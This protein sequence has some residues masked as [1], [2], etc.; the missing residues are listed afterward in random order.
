MT[1]LALYAATAAL[2]A[3]APIDS[4]PPDPGVDTTAP[5]PAEEAAPAQ[6]PT[7]AERPAA[8]H[9][10]LPRRPP[11]REERAAPPDDA[12]AREGTPG[13]QDSM[14]AYLFQQQTWT[15]P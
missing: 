1:T 6:D 12:A 5:P 9:R 15:G 7:T 10:V 11:I 8:P 14:D 2:M 13:F 4:A 3:T